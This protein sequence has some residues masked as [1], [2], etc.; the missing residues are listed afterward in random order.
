MEQII[1]MPKT[2]NIDIESFS[3][4]SQLQ[5]TIIDSNA[6]EIVLDFT[7]CT[8]SHALFT[9]FIG[10]LSHIGSTFGKTIVYRSIRGSKLNTYFRRSG[11]AAP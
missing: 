10:A 5:N 4:L 2:L 6:S 8:F 9:S 1:A 7:N 3:F 11:C